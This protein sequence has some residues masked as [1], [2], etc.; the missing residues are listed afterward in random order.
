MN[1]ITPVIIS[2]LISQ[3][4]MGTINLDITALLGELELDDLGDLLHWLVIFPGT[5]WCGPGNIAAN[6]DDLGLAAE[7]DMCCRAHDFCGD[8]FS[9]YE[10]KYNLTNLAFYTRLNCTCDDKFYTCLKDVDS[11]FS[12]KIGNIFFNLL[13]TQCFREDYPIVRCEK[14]TYIP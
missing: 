4:W 10:T 7:T 13:G 1:K 3:V 9:P 6:Y 8:T 11:T 12:R 5:K 14:Y 2:M